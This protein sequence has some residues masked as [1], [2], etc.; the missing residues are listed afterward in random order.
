MIIS[1]SK[2]VL[3]KLEMAA[4][5]ALPN[6]A[7][8]LLLGHASNNIEIEDCVITDNVTTGLR[9]N[10]FEIDP[11]VHLRLQRKARAGGPQVIGVWHSHPN[12]IAELSVT[13]KEV[14]CEQGWVWLLTAVSEAGPETGAFL[15]SQED[16]QV[17]SKADLTVIF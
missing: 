17:F 5:S 1:L 8:G 3:N 9:T 4:V 11:T 16:A 13:D 14:S 7:C 12:G 6:E 15:A 2:Q 10:S